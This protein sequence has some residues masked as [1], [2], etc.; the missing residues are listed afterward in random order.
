MAN[1]YAA[2][3]VWADASQDEIRSTY[4]RLA[5]TV[6]LMLVFFAVLVQTSAP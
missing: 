6:I 5:G 2:L 1:H 4:R 3:G